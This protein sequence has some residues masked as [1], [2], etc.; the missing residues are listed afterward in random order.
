LSSIVVYCQ[1]DDAK[2][3]KKGQVVIE[4][5]TKMLN[6]SQTIIVLWAWFQDWFSCDIP[7][8][9]FVIDLV[10]IVNQVVL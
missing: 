9:L 10:N 4:N 7:V 3:V 2:H 8:S 6:L 5:R 1:N